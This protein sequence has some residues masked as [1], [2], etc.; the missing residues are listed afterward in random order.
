MATIRDYIELGRPF[1]LIAPA[2]GFFS[3]AITAIGAAPHEVW[4]WPLLV[5]PITGASPRPSS[6]RTARPEAAGEKRTTSTAPGT[7]WTA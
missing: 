7:R 6:A 1:T 5:P 3:G 2:L 4:S